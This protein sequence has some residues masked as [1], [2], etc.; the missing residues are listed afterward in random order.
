MTFHAEWL[1]RI[2]CSIL[3]G[4]VVGYER[5]RR[6]K[7][8]GI[9][10]H[11][12]VAM[13]SCLLMLISK[14]GF[15]DASRFDPSRIASSVVSGVGFLGAGIIFVQNGSTHG[16]TTAAGV[17]AVAAIGMAFGAGMYQLG[18]ICGVLMF[19]IEAFF[20]KTF[21]FNPPYNSVTLSFLL[22]ED[23]DP[24]D[25]NDMLMEMGYNHSD[26]NIS[27]SADGYTLQTTIR[28]NKT[29]QIKEVREKLKTIPHVRDVKIL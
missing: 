27:A 25:I 22:D 4:F 11:M 14:Y 23:F 10:T 21:S 8:A 12:I 7:E 1:L 15:E 3:V 28:T 6:S 2:A 13:A 24:K 9:R 19:V 17:W 26:N 18:S 29:F 16:L 5:H 20:K